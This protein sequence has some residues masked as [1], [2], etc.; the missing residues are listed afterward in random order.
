V[1]EEFATSATAQLPNGNYAPPSVVPVVIVADNTQLPN[2]QED[3]EVDTSPF[4]TYLQSPQGHEITKSVVEIIQDIKKAALSQSAG[5][6]KLEKYLQLGIVVT[7]IIAASVLA[8]MGKL[9]STISVLFG[10][11]VGYVFGRKS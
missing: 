2:E 9:E 11:L 5:Q 3:E 8:G 4:F 10:T 6:A 7:V 1:S